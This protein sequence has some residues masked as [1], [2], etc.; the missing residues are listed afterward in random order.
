MELPFGGVTLKCDK[1]QEA[2]TYP[3]VEP[4]FEAPIQLGRI[5]HALPI[6]IIWGAPSELM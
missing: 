1:K 6:H 5:C 2:I 4:H 3:D